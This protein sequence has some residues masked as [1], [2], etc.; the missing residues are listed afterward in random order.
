MTG[1]SYTYT[2]KSVNC[3]DSATDRSRNEINISHLKL[4]ATW[5][6]DNYA[7]LLS[8]DGLSNSTFVTDSM[9]SNRTAWSELLL[10]SHIAIYINETKYPVLHMR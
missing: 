1:E 10:T 9:Q 8:L 5:Q 4:M 6:E 3:Q 7:V 2:S